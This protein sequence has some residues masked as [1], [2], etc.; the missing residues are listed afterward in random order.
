MVHERPV[1]A[2]MSAT[3]KRHPVVDAGVNAN[4]PV[5]RRV[6]PWEQW[7]VLCVEQLVHLLD[8]GSPTLQ[9]HAP[10]VTGR[11]VVAVDL[12]GDGRAEDG[13]GK[14]GASAVGER[15]CRDRRRS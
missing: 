2:A 11:R 10:R 13:G 12:E 4:E 1:M 9:H 14:L 15:P 3:A 5:L 8:F 7:E 6:L